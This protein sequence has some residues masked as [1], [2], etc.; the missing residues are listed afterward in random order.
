MASVNT[1][2]TLTGLFREVYGDDIQKLLPEVAKL[3]KRVPFKEQEKIG[4]KF[5]QPVVLAREHGV[6]Y[7][8]A[9]DGAFALNTPIAMQMGSAEID[10][11]QLLL[12]SRLDYE[13][14][15]KA[16][17]GKKAFAN[18]TQ[19]L[20]ETMME[21]A[22]HRVEVSMLYGQSGI[23]K[24]LSESGSGTTRVY[25][26]QTASFAAG[27][28]AGAENAELDFYD[29]S[30]KLNTNAAVVVTA[31]DLD[32]RTISVSGNASDLTAIDAATL[33]DI[34]FKG[35][36]GKEMVGIDKILTNT[37]SL[38]GIN[39]GTYGMWKASSYSA[40][41]AALTMAKVLQ[42]VGKAVSRGLN[43]D[44]T[45]LVNPITWGNL[46]SDQAGLRSFDQSYSSKESKNGSESIVYFGQ[47]GKIEIVSHPCV[48]EGEAFVV[49][50]KKL[51]RI[52]AQELSFKSPGSDEQLFRQLDSNAGVELRLYG[53]QAIFIETPARCVK[54]TNIVNS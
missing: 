5:V 44:V 22:A 39:A 23:G 12:A 52:G 41:S 54:I 24:Q 42:A 21:S 35:S 30:T 14:A 26:L 2:S 25:T 36:Y 6:T 3:Q 1:T 13:S 9:G 38:F 45:V 16:A 40:G 19:H 34:Y 7:Q 11:S 17:S 10:G 47:N 33:P 20:I 32:A 31:V 27:I 8:A 29:G 50:M 53:N 28:W 46:N 43:E 48:K 15:A 51:K 49:P 4:K 18:A 37:G